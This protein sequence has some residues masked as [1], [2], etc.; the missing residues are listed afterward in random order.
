MNKSAFQFVFSPQK[1]LKLSAA[2]GAASLVFALY[3]QH[4]DGHEPCSLCML[5]RLMMLGMVL[6]AATGLLLMKKSYV[7]WTSLLASATFACAGAYWS[8][9]QLN[10]LN[11][12]G[13]GLSK[14]A[15][16]LDNS[17][18]STA[19]PWL[20]EI[21]AMCAGDLATWVGLT[22]PTWGLLVYTTCAAAL[23]LSIVIKAVSLGGDK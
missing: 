22:F 13:C 18:L 14:T 1:T 3:A 23:I 2:L 4:V 15:L 11:R 7:L 20:L 21:R 12:M 9:Y 8:I 19:L 5:S 6:S 10:P 16:F 17:G